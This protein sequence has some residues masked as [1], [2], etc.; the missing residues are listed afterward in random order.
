M[1]RTHP[2]P[3]ATVQRHLVPCCDHCWLCSRA[4]WTTD[5]NHRTVTTLAGLV[6]CTLPSGEPPTG[7][8]LQ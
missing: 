4:L 1:A 7:W 6:A 5:T 2:R 3:E 8:Q